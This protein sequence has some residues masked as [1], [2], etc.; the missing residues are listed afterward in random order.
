V[1]GT[2]ATA[3]VQVRVSPAVQLELRR[4]ATASGTDVSNVLRD[5]IDDCV[6]GRRPLVFCTPKL[7]G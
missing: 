4:V 2:G 1:Y 6:E 3:R 7:K 5:L